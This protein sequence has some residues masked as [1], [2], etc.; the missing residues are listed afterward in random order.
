MHMQTYTYKQVAGVDLSIDVHLPR[1]EGPWPVV[2]SLHG[3]ALILGSRAWLPEGLFDRLLAEGVAVVSPDYRLAPETKLP[4]IWSDVV[5][6][7]AWVRNA[8]PDVF[9]ARPDHVGVHGIS[10]GGYL[11]LLCGCRLDPLPRVVGSF[12]GYGNILAPWYAEADEWYRAQP[13]VSEKEA[14]AAVGQGVPTDGNTGKDRGRYYVYL[15]QQG[16]WPDAVGGIDR[17]ALKAYCP[18]MHV[19]ER[20]P[21]AVLYHGTID[22][23]VPFAESENFASQLEKHSVEHLFLPLEDVDHVSEGAEPEAFD[24]VV[25]QTAAFMLSRLERD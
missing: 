15:R 23:D 16:M 7:F 4:E 20:F 10:A 19:T 8:G 13:M 9:S 1:G 22:H 2:V 25:R 18:V 5:D 11:A 12:A 24:D 6:A 14:G 17:E 3:G 21:P